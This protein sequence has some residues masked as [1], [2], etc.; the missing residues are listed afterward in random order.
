MSTNTSTAPRAWLPEDV[1][2]LVVQPVGE[3]SIAARA[4]AYRTGLTGNALRVP[5]VT[6]DPTAAWVGE[7]EEIPVS[8]NE[9][10]EAEAAYRK[11]A[12]LSVVS[13][14]LADDTDPDAAQE[15]GRG[16]VRDIARKL[17]HA[18][19]NDAGAKAPA[20]LATLAGVS[21]VA[22]PVELT[23]LDP[24][25]SAK[26]KA[27]A[28][29]AQ[30]AAFVLSPNDAE[31]LALLKESSTSAKRL[32]TDNAAQPGAMVLDGVP[33][34]TSPAV[35]DGTSW[36]LPQNRVIVGVRKDASVE[37]DRSAFFTSD[38]V[39]IRATMRVAF[40]FPHPAAIVKILR[41]AA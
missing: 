2:S 32:L 38:R 27:A 25:I 22:A 29:G 6:A 8:Q 33:V 17:D 9:L 10:D 7:G 18:L 11:L 24:Y 20:G 34:L 15:I 16:L 39:A 26:F 31:E 5:L 40:A 1:L 3:E 23:N 35:A 14:E 36:A 37:A 13:T 19:F 28:V 21:S 30:L 12:G 4:G 41:V